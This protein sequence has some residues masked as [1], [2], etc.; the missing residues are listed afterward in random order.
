M[1][2]NRWLFENEYSQTDLAKKLNLHFRTI[3]AIYR[4]RCMPSLPVAAAIVKFTNGEV[5]FEDL[6][7]PEAKESLKKIIPRGK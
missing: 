6:L 2:L 4:K 5:S 3:H 1:E 7:L